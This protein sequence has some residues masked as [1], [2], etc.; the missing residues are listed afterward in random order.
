M[1]HRPLQEKDS[2]FSMCTRGNNK[3]NK[4]IYQKLET[5]P[6]QQ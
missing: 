4:Q 1:K 2:A 6:N 5:S 3:K